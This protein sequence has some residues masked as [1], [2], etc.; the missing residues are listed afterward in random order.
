MATKL[1]PDRDA[2]NDQQRR[3]RGYARNRK[4]GAFALVAVM[5]VAAFVVVK[6]VGAEDGS[7]VVPGESVPPASV[8]PFDATPHQ[9]GIVG[10]DGSM[11]QA[12][13]GLPTDAFAPTLSADGGRLAYATTVDGH[14]QIAVVGSDGLG[15]R[16]IT[17]QQF[18]ANNASWSP[19]GDRIAFLGLTVNGDHDIYVIDADG[20]NQVRLTRGPSDDMNPQWSPDGNAIVY[21]SSPS[22]DEFSA[23][24]EIWEIVPGGD[25]EPVRLTDNHVL[26]SMPSWSP[27]GSEIVFIRGSGF[28]RMSADGAHQRP[29]VA[30]H[31]VEGFSPAWSPDG[32]SVAFLRY[33]DNMANVVV[34]G[35]LERG[36]AV[37][38]VHI[39]ELASGDVHDVGLRVGSDWNRPQW[40]GSD[41]LLVNQLLSQPEKT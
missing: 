9:V 11:Q 13:L 12:I 23:G 3:Q 8:G 19:D 10:L 16:V 40:V 24:R 33:E 41:A 30:G 14:A 2:W 17:D 38:S 4:L 7:N 29:L 18:E 28:W 22:T 20:L 21:D 15:A 36:T 1:D 31:D 5:A 6:A 25:A 39:V 37:L 26:D 35:Y 34:H 32:A 27:D